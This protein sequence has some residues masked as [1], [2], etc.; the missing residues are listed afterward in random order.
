[1]VLVTGATGLVGTHLLIILL[2]EQQ[3]VR[4]L[5]RTATK[6]EH[7]RQFFLDHYP[8]MEQE[9]LSTI[10]AL[11]DSIEWVQTSIDNIPELQEAFDGV[12][13]VYHCAAMISF[14]PKKYKTLRKTNIKGTATIV[15][16]CIQHHVQKL[17]YVST[18]AILNE[19]PGKVLLDETSPWNPEA[20]NS[21][22]GITKY[23][24]E[25]EVWRASQEGVPV[26]IVNPG[27]IIGSGF[28]T[29]GSGSIFAK[30][31]AGN[32]YYSAGGSG[33]VSVTD[34]VQ[35][36]IQL[37]K[38]PIVNE[39][40]VLVAE[41]LEYKTVLTQVAKAMNVKAPRREASLFLMQCLRVVEYVGYF[42]FRS[43][44]RMTKAAIKSLTTRSAY[45]NTKIVQALDYT[46]EPMAQVLEK[47]AEDFLQT[48][49]K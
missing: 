39:R 12:T 2:Q 21:V 34:V 32:P 29:S 5:Y 13:Q 35:I 40:F 33:F 3:T 17:C 26:V 48:Q 46:F 28:Y 44:V 37:M 10:S 45:D 30:T 25:I 49:Q 36:M 23:G 14:D 1:M 7:T 9:Q 27:V 20:R 42:L 15:N 43:K 16:L 24:A 18:I 38:S 8:R 22:Y 11:F 4:A 47:T 6:R 41:N 31:Y 19:T